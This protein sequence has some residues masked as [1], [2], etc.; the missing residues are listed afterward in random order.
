VE[1]LETIFKDFKEKSEKRFD[2]FDIEESV[3]DLTKIQDEAYLENSTWLGGDEKFICLAIDLDRSSILSA[4]KNVK[5]MARLY[6][7]FTQNIVDVLN[8]EEIKADYIDIKGDGVFGIYQGE[9]AVKRAF[10]AAVTFR[11]F[12]ENHIKTKF[13][14]ALGIDLNCK[15]A[16]YRDK[17]LVKRI[18]TRK[19]NNEVWA[20][21]L[22]NNTYKLMKLSDRIRETTTTPITQSIL[23]ISEEIHTHLSDHHYDH[24]VMSCGCKTADGVPLDLWTASDTTM[25]EDVLGDRAYYMHHIW[26]DNCG[27]TYLLE[28]LNS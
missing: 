5:T 27:N 28:I 26:C 13:R 2:A 7:Y 21:R 1:N 9:D 20:G 6:E 3:G 14:S 10:I 19:Y 16:I 17:I 24:A 15:A 23:I 12:F 22:V 18:G 11:T 8:L 4:R 25:E